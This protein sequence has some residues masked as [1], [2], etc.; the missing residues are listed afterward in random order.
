MYLISFV[1][2]FTAITLYVNNEHVL[3]QIK[4]FNT[5]IPFFMLKC[6]WYTFLFASSHKRHCVD[7]CL[8]Y[9]SLQL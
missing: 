4:V 9:L 6:Q 7:A 5:N 1:I 2:L 3:F 8:L